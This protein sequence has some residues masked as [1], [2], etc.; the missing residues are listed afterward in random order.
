MRLNNRFNFP[1]G[2]IKLFLLLS[3]LYLLACPLGATVGNFCLSCCVH[4]TSFMLCS[5]DVFHAVFTWRLS[6]CVHVTS[7]LLCSCDVLLAVFVWRLSGYVHVTSFLVCSRDVFLAVF[8]WRFS[9]CVPMK[10][11]L[12]GSRD[13][14]LAVF[15]WRLSCCVHVTSFWLCSCDVFFAAFTWRLSC[16][17][18]VTSFE[19]C[20]LSLFCWIKLS[21]ACGPCTWGEPRWPP[22]WHPCARNVPH[23]PDRTRCQRPDTPG[24]WACREADRDWPGIPSLWCTYCLQSHN[25]VIFNAF[26]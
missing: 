14:F 23:P 26:P 18:N 20:Q 3:L 8:M 22:P 13:V 10:S 9:G 16:S 24:S 2:W 12:L 25:T 17:V 4:V 6:C 19:P 7:F 1:P 11:F 15:T 21:P 5:R